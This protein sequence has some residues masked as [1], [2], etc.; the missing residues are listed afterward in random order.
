MARRLGSCGGSSRGGGARLLLWNDAVDEF[1]LTIC[2]FIFG[3]Q[4]APTP[5]E[6]SG[7]L[8]KEGRKLELISV[9]Q[10][11]QEVFLHYKVIRD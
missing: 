7:W 6:G 10:I 5:V 1:Y 2:P 9:K 11:E 4:N 3:G 8:Q